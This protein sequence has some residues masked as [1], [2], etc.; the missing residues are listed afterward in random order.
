MSFR[1][2]E[3]VI[4]AVLPSALLLLGLFFASMQ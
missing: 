3:D 1:E 2:I 4:F